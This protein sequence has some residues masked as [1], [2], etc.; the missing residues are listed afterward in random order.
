MPL[1]GLELGLGFRIGEV[2]AVNRHQKQSITVREI[3]PYSLEP[4]PY[5]MDTASQYAV[6]SEE[7][8]LRG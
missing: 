1:S 8:H 4:K 2:V 6:T 7:V 5:I 3:V